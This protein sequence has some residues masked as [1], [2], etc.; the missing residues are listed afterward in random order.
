MHS[1]FIQL[2]TELLR[3]PLIACKHVMVYDSADRR[4]VYHGFHYVCDIPS[5]TF[6]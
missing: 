2:R 3:S 4:Q 6:I 1:C 5:K